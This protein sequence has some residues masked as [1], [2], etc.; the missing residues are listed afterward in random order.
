M[1]DPSIVSIKYQGL[2]CIRAQVQRTQ[3]LEPDRGSV[4]IPT[5]PGKPNFKMVQAGFWRKINGDPEGGDT[6]ALPRGDGEAAP[7]GAPQTILPFGDLELD[8]GDN[9]QSPRSSVKLPDLY[10][11]DMVEIDKGVDPRDNTKRSIYR[12]TLTDFRYMWRSNGV[13]F[14]DRNMVI[15]QARSSEVGVAI[16]L[17]PSELT[18]DAKILRRA[19]ETVADLGVGAFPRKA[20]P[21]DPRG[22]QGHL[23]L[24][25]RTLF[26]FTDKKPW[27]LKQLIAECIAALPWAETYGDKQRVREMPDGLEKEIPFN[28]K[29]GSGTRA[30]KALRELLSLYGLVL[31]LNYENS[32]SIFREFTEPEGVGVNESKTPRE[33]GIEFKLQDQTTDRA[34]YNQPPRMVH[35][36][37]PRLWQ[38]E[39]AAD[40][41]PVIANDG[42]MNPVTKKQES[43]TNWAEGEIVSLFDFLQAIKYD[44]D[45][46]RRQVLNNEE[47]SFVDVP[48]DEPFIKE[49]RI[50]LLRRYAWKMFRMKEPSNF[51]LPMLTDE[52]GTPFRCSIQSDGT[53]LSRS[54]M[55]LKADTFRVAPNF[56]VGTGWTSKDGFVG[57]L[58]NPA[59]DEVE[60]MEDTPMGWFVNNR[61]WD[62]RDTF[63]K[64]IWPQ[65]GR[66]LFSRVMGTIE[67]VTQR[68]DN[69]EYNRLTRKFE[70]AARAR[71]DLAE[72]REKRIKKWQEALHLS[73]NQKTHVAQLIATLGAGAF[74]G[75]L[76]LAD[77]ANGRFQEA[78]EDSS[79]FHD[80][81]AKLDKLAAENRALLWQGMKS[82]FKVIFGNGERASFYDINNPPGAKPVEAP[83]VDERSHGG[84]ETAPDFTTLWDASLVDPEISLVY[85]WERNYG[86]GSDYYGFTFPNP[87]LGRET[88]L[89]A[90][91][92]HDESLRQWVSS[93]GITNLL[94]L[95]VLAAGKARKHIDNV[96]VISEGTDWRFVGF[97]Q[98]LL[99][100]RVKQMAWTAGSDGTAETEVGEDRN[101]PGFKGSPG[102]NM[103]MPSRQNFYGGAMIR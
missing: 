77:I 52:T 22:T 99:S 101:G 26:S 41:E 74:S 51:H 5:P 87:N 95:D 32:V 45:K 89:P 98:V 103:T 92:I 94:A 25:R 29:W 13:V 82:P 40:W 4:D 97:H 7:D 48:G 71:Q 39:I 47:V 6:V 10:V 73:Y 16:Q 46:A 1:P 31:V 64:Q 70:A 60:G 81:L 85:T 78:L 9:E 90:D 8:M 18:L 42:R 36:S 86:F 88:P 27:N 19:K 79:G 53:S 80:A 72:S 55:I 91:L 83:T 35:V 84:K 24:D 65:E 12:A 3:G 63:I 50:D 69:R 61:L 43:E 102:V 76:T 17:V 68:V 37:G 11:T 49:R 93:A 54:R 38:E 96:A 20:N 23:I 58:G 67:T 59:G 2:P 34:S 33:V 21:E 100:G 66:I 57:D 44:E 14:T 75:G 56:R 15:E 62:V 30:E 28:L